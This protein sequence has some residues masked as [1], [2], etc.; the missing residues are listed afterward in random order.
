MA[1]KMDVK[2]KICLTHEF[3]ASF[4]NV[5]EAKSY[6]GQEAK[7]SLTMLFDK[8]VDLAKPAT[9]KKGEPLSVS[10]KE[11]AFNCAVEKWGPQK[12]WPKNLRIP[13][14]DGDEKSDTQGYAGHIFVTASSKKQPGLVDG[15]RKPILNAADFYS[16][17]YARAEVI[18][19][20]YDVSGNK[21]VS[22]SL[23]NIQKLRDGDPFG[24]R[25]NAEDV[26]DSVEDTTQAEQKP[27]DNFGF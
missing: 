11:A 14:R 26:F 15:Q 8:K 7:Y 1:E 21:G 24:G 2:K 19:F 23:Q 17:C 16:G 5:F 18:A 10:M 9:N 20:A 4:C 6:Q 25:R 22:F 12:D 3:R 27:V 13:F